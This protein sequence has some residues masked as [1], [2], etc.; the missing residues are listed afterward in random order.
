MLLL[1][2][3]TPAHEL[4]AL[5]VHL[6]G[7]ALFDLPQLVVADAGQPHVPVFLCVGMHKSKSKL[8][9]RLL[10]ICELLTER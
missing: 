9:T 5:S 7:R 6:G 3:L 2:F 8:V 1:Y 4:R 10:K